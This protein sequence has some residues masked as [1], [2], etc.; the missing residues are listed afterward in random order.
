M[1]KAPNVPQSEHLLRMES[2]YLI[3]NYQR[4]E[5]MVKSTIRYCH[6]T[7][8]CTERYQLCHSVKHS[9][10]NREPLAKWKTNRW[11]VFHPSIWYKYY[12]MHVINRWKCNSNEI[13][14]KKKKKNVWKMKNKIKTEHT[15][16]HTHVRKRNAYS[17]YAAFFPTKKL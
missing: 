2:T 15:H 12:A 5:P 13:Q 16:T 3:L 14:K 9:K 4:A 1:N 8:L 6:L 11:S 10:I 7:F 17:C